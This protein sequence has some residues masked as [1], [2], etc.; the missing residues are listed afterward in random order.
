MPEKSPSR[1]SYPLRPSDELRAKLETAAK[2]RGR[3]LHAEIINRL[4]KT[5]ELDSVNKEFDNSIANSQRIYKKLEDS[6]SRLLKVYLN[7]M[8]IALGITRDA[9]KTMR[10]HNLPEY[11]YR[12][13]EATSDDLAEMIKN[14]RDDKP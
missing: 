11:E 9:V 2:E 8:S 12:H 3:S 13:I 4:E 10:R 14:L 7:V 1:T 5:F 6:H